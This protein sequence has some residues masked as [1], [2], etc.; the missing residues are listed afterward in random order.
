MNRKNTILLAIFINAA[1][2]IVLFGM[3]LTTQEEIALAPTHEISH[4]SKPLAQER[5]LAQA[6]P[7]MFEDELD[8]ILRTKSTPV[9]T[10]LPEVGLIEPAPGKSEIASIVHSLPP[11]QPQ[12]VTPQQSDVVPPMNLA[13]NA[14]PE[15]HVKKG[16]TLEKLAKAHHTTVDEIIKL[17]HLPSSF[18]RVGQVLKLPLE[19][20]TSAKLNPVEKPAPASG[21]DYYTIKVG[22]NPWMI[23]MKHHLKLEELLK[24]N[25]LNEE[26]ARKLKPGDRLR[27]K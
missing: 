21:P 9:L 11:V 27:I 26:K 14:H 12:V 17:N 22:D 5:S 3:A 15:T 23:A 8:L 7:P 25:G 10:A 1:L 24:L 18:L 16:D 6:E 20:T 2:L 19:K 4:V 13:V